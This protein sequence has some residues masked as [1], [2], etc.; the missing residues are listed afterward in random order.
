MVFNRIQP[1]GSI[2]HFVDCYWMVDDED[3]TVKIQKI[4]PDGFAEIIFHYGD[5]YKIQI[6]DDWELQSDFL[7]AGQITKY[8]YLANC[9][10]TGSFGIK[11]KPA[12][13]SHIFNLSMKEYTD[14][15]V[16]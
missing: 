5:P 6:E 10:R 9:G 8:F 7:L 16:S 11:F 13:V 12:A 14:K 1:S 2:K 3:M 4:I 15:V